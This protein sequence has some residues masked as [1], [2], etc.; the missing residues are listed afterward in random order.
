MGTLMKALLFA[1]ALCLGAAPAI[2]RDD[3]PNIDAIW[4]PQV[5]S[6]TYHADD[7]IYTCTGQRQKITG[8]IA[9]IGARTNVP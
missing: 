6:F 5:V 7:T 1:A 3:N 4:L 9:Q 2:A 8:I